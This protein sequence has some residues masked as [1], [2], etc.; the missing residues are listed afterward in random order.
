[1]NAPR[2]RRVIAVVTTALLAVT[3]CGTDSPTDPRP[4]PVPEPPVAYTHVWSA[5]PD[6]DLSSR[7]AELVRAAVEAGLRTFN[8]GTKFTFPGYLDAVG[9][10]Y[11]FDHG[12]VWDHLVR[13][14]PVD[15]P[16]WRA[17]YFMHL[18]ALSATATEVTGAVCEYGVGTE[19]GE[20]YSVYPLRMVRAVTLRNTAE[21][22]GAAGIPDT[23]AEGHDPR[24]AI[25]PD[26]DVFGTWKIVQLRTGGPN[27]VIPDTCTAWW[28]ERFPTFEL[29]DG[30][31]SPPPGFEPPTMPVAQQYPEWIGP[32]S[33]G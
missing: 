13:P 12:E 23:D 33:A 11:D 6:I 28:H 17:T 21:T 25:A 10:P 18:T 27:W 26:W 19:P 5:D 16:Q 4:V 3:G 31:L 29:H 22:P 14:G 32:A 24:A 2:R 15:P 20:E 30:L 1:M 7:G 9:A 8:Y